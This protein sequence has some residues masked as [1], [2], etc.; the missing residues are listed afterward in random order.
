M[1]FRYLLVVLLTCCLQLHAQTDNKKASKVEVDDEA[2]NFIV[3]GDWGRR[4]EGHQKEVAL[5][6]GKTASEASVDFIIATGDNFYNSG[7]QS[8]HDPL[9]R[10]SFEDIYS[11]YSLQCDWYPVLGNHDY[12]T[13][14]EAQVTYSTISGRWKMPA[15]CYTRKFDLQG[16][17]TNQ[18]LFIFIDT[19][20]L[21][22]KYYADDRHKVH[23]QDSAAQKV[24][25]E[26][27]LATASANVKWKIVVGHHPMYTGGKRTENHDTR[28]I[29]FML[30]P[31][32]EKYGVDAYLA[33]HEHSLQHIGPVK[34]VHHFIS[35]AA[36][37]RTPA[38][39]LPISKF[40]GSHYGF[41]LF[42]ATKD[43]LLVQVINH[44][45]KILYVTK[46]HQ[47]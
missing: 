20:P 44:K 45:G 42:S 17:S 41:M 8:E 3:M 37:E 23:D 6:M 14:P 15:R 11:A 34:N 26:N 38:R 5:Q 36:S 31:L 35:G 19:T 24:W 12:G 22:A 32:F 33:G 39:M 10:Y 9:W 28:S 30:E 16:D 47:N 40:A 43:R 2:L 29:R 46:L 25:L 13:N 18:L 27:L 7:V 1:T 4:G 21:I